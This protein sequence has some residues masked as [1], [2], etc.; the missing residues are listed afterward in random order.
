MVSVLSSSYNSARETLNLYS[1]LR[2]KSEGSTE[3]E[4]QTL[5]QDRIIGAGSE[6]P[7]VDIFLAQ[8]HEQ[9]CSLPLLLFALLQCD[10]FRQQ[11]DLYRPSRDARCAASRAMATMPP[12]ALARCIAPR[13]DCWEGGLT[14]EATH[15]IIDLNRRA[16]DVIQSKAWSTNSSGVAFVIDSSYQTIV[17]N[18]SRDEKQM[19]GFGSEIMQEVTRIARTYRSAPPLYILNGENES[20]WR[21]QEALIEDSEMYD[22]KAFYE[23]CSDIADEVAHD[24]DL[25]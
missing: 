19:S 16:L 14:T 7:N 13:I 21:F 11:S 22:G 23:W 20:V 25:N 3:I 18:S 24:L 9:L 10:I 4:S 1:E 17:W 2:Q 8:G 12:A 6:M 15:Q 5:L